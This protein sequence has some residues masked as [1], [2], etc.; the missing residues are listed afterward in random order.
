MLN[1]PLFSKHW[2]F[3]INLHIS[4][5]I[6][7]SNTLQNFKTG[8]IIQKL[9]VSW[10]I[11]FL[12]GSFFFSVFFFITFFIYLYC[13]WRRQ[14]IYIAVG[15]D[16]LNRLVQPQTSIFFSVRQTE[17]AAAVETA[18]WAP[19]MDN[20]RLWPPL[21]SPFFFF[22][23]SKPL[24]L[25]QLIMILNNEERALYLFLYPHTNEERTATPFL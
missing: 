2:S 7:N 19:Q 21:S 3:N 15:G 17:A 16:R 6:T 18:T 13:R 25:N 1:W 12:V 9:I 11:I 14:T 24:A 20:Q 23:S 5:W 4:F 22:S 10:Q 8:S